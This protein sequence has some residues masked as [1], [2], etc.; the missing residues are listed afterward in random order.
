[1]KDFKGIL[2]L[3][4]LCA[5]LLAIPFGSVAQEA[6]QLV[7]PIGHKYRVNSVVFSHDGRDVHYG[8]R[9]GT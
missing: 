1:M 4:S 9:D 3:L 8:S 6:P 7:L 2:I 5:G